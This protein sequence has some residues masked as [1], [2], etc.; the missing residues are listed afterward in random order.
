[1]QKNAI[2]VG[3]CRH[4]TRIG[5]NKKWRRICRH[6]ITRDAAVFG[7][8]ESGSIRFKEDLGAVINQA[9][10]KGIKVIAFVQQTEKYADAEDHSVP[11]AV[12]SSRTAEV[13]G[14]QADVLLKIE[15]FSK[16]AKYVIEVEN[17]DET[18]PT[19]QAAAENLYITHPEVKASINDET[20]L[21]GTVTSVTGADFDWE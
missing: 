15:E 2:H 16:K 20:P 4:F 5:S 9:M 21:R 10:E 18:A 12:F 7:K 14:K 8:T 17:A 3:S 6:L 13:N 19:G 1:M 11:V